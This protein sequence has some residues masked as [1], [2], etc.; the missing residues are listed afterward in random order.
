[1][2]GYIENESAYSAAVKRC[3]VSNAYITFARTSARNARLSDILQG[4]DYERSEL[5][6][7]FRESLLYKYGKLSIKQ[8]DAAYK[9]IADNQERKAGRESKWAERDAAKALSAQWV[10]AV[11]DKL[12][13]MLT[14]QHV[15][16]VQGA[17][18][19]YGDTGVSYMYMCEDELGN[20]VVYKGTS[21]SFPSKG[22]GAL[23]ACT[24][25]SHNVYKN[26]KQTFIQRPK[27]LDSFALSKGKI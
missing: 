21:S 25:K 20:P 15:V 17:S 3:I 16:T 8:V 10:G 6:D 1:M 18:M 5:L 11:G 12:V 27:V 24:V 23:V 22:E 4:L 7:Q 14:C 19:Y 2:S 13:M 9:I 26:T